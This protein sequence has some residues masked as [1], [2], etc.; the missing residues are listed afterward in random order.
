VSTDEQHHPEPVAIA[1]FATLGEA[2]VA[3]ALLRSAGIESSIDD[4]GEGGILPIQ[5]GGSVSLEV[6]ATD[7]EMAQALLTAPTAG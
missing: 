6:K 4:Q 2:E 5:G 1:A 7:A 3:Q